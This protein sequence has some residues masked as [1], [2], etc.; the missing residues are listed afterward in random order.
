MTQICHSYIFVTKST[1]FKHMITFLISKSYQF[2]LL[3][4][5]IIDIFEL[6]SLFNFYNNLKTLRVYRVDNRGKKQAFLSNNKSKIKFKKQKV[7]KFWIPFTELGKT[8]QLC[9]KQSLMTKTAFKILPKVKLQ[10]F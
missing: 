4:L 6:L 3:H 7:K 5:R 1:Y 9:C 8:K 10:Q 2:L